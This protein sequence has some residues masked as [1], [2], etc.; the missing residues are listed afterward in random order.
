MTTVNNAELGLVL[1]RQSCWKYV[2]PLQLKVLQWLHPRRWFL[3]LFPNTQN[4]DEVC[5][6]NTHTNERSTVE[7]A[8]GLQKAQ[9]W[10]LNFISCHSGD[11][12]CYL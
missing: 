12:K 11:H 7:H 8:I 10:C 1:E 2:I 4:A 5:F 6:N 9:W 3:T